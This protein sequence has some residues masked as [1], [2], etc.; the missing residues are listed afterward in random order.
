MKSL[1]GS[2]RCIVVFTMVSIWLVGCISN[3]SSVPVPISSINDNNGDI[4]IKK[5]IS[6][7][8]QINRPRASMNISEPMNFSKKGSIIYNRRYNNDLKGSY[9][10]FT[11]Q[12]KHGDTLFYIAW[13]TGNNYR[14]LAKQNN[15]SAPYNLKVGQILQVHD[16]VIINNSN[17]SIPNLL[18]T[19]VTSTPSINTQI[20]KSSLGLNRKNNDLKNLGKHDIGKKV[21]ENKLINSWNWPTNGRIIDSFSTK[22]GGNKGVDISGML[23]Q[24]IL[25]AASGKVVYAGNA[26]RGYGNLII[27]KHNDDYLSAYAHNNTLLVHEQQEVNRG[28][29]I[30]TMGSSGASSVR[31]HFEI[32][33]QGKSVNPLRYLPRRQ[34]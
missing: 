9:S 12:V 19:A 17:N 23:G 21:D 25:A 32:R 24:P 13:L 27:I 11:Y 26:L 30:A 6:H 10:G 2:L 1:E 29:K 18:S 28:Q 8:P 5:I 34:I 33:Y 4:D 16:K 20:T 14:E 15:I 7:A 22:E 31:L 3:N